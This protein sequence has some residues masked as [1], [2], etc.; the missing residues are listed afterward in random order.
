MLSLN[1]N[2]VEQYEGANVNERIDVV[3]DLMAQGASTKG[4]QSACHQ[5]L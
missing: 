5:T 2:T 1:I 3:G 4:W